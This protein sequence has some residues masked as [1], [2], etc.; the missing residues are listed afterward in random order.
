MPTA[1]RETLPASKCPPATIQTPPTAVPN[2][3]IQTTGG[4]PYNNGS[5]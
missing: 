4:T 1:T 2:G 5:K 3:N